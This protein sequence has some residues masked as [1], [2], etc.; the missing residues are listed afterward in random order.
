MKSKMNPCPKCGNRIPKIFIVN[1]VKN[2]FHINSYIKIG[3]PKC[4]YEYVY[5]IK[6]DMN[7]V[8]PFDY[9]E[10]QKKEAIKKWNDGEESFSIEPLS[11]EQKRALLASIQA[12]YFQKLHCT[13]IS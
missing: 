10:Q 4:G 3:C 1:H 13:N 7:A 5:P 2:Y 8:I 12:S 11:D 6:E 9:L